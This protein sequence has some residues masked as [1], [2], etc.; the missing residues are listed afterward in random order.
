M[1]QEV[2][3]IQH[4]TISRNMLPARDALSKKLEIGNELQ[5]ASNEKKR[6][7]QNVVRHCGKIEQRLQVQYSIWQ[8]VVTSLNRNQW[9]IL[10]WY[11]EYIM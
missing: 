1:I 4:D 6:K 5:A 10:L 7:I 8:S 2:K 11:A 9:K 3:T